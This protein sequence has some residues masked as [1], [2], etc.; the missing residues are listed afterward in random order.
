MLR[1]QN[2]CSTFIQDC[3]SLN[4]FVVGFR[5]CSN[6]ISRQFRD[7][8][9]LYTHPG[10]PSFGCG[11]TLMVTCQQCASAYARYVYVLVQGR[12]TLVICEQNTTRKCIIILG[13]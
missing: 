4:N 12:Q 1:L 3:D 5:I 10:S 13:S 9:I 11:R 2:E 8:G 7:E 6:M